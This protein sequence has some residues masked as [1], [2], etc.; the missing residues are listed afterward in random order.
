MVPSELRVILIFRIVRFLK[1][2]RYSPAI[3]SLLDALYSERRAL[4]GCVIIL[5]GTALIAAS[6][7]HLAERGVQPDKLG[8]IPDAM[9]W[10][11]VTLGTIGYGDVVPITPLGKIIASVTIFGGLIM[12]ALPVGIIA[13]AFSEQIHRRDFVVTWSMV[14]RVPL[15]AGLDAGEIADVLRLL[16]AQTVDSGDVIVRRGDAAHS[17]YFIA[18]GEVEIDL[19]TKHIRLG[20]GHFFGEVAVLRR[21]RRSATVTAATRTSLLVLDAEDMH[22]LMEREPRIA[23]R[24]N[25]S[26]RSR[27]G[28]DV[29]SPKGDIVTE[30]LE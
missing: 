18:A 30:E 24:I 10:A 16:R 20:V 13:T 3:R 11:I 26:V 6:L 12:I 29:I 25:E 22:A 17:M 15:F 28:H 1:L 2:A 14:A 7:M 19:G 27:G 21:A 23:E 8:T 9:W 4:F 5:L